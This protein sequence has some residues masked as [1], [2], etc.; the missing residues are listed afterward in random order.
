M[1]VRFVFRLLTML[2]VAVAF[3]R[4]GS[5][6]AAEPGPADFLAFVRSEGER[7]RATDRPPKTREEWEAR[8]GVIRERL[9]AAWGGFAAQ[10]APLEA[11]KLGEI[12]RD[13]YRVE[14]VTFQTLPGVR[15]LANAYVPDRPGKVP[16]VL[17]VHG[18]WPRAKQDPV[19][20]GRCIGLA[21]LG[22]FVLAVDAF[23]AGERAIGTALGEYHGA[24]TGALLFPIGRP[25]SGIQVY[26]NMRCVDYLA[27]RPEVDAAKIGVT[28]ASGG[29]N[30]SMYAGAFE[31]RF[32]AAVPVCSVGNYQAYLGAACCMCEVVP[33]A[34][35]FTE[36]G[37]L[38]G[39]T[40]PR[41]LMVI[42]ATRDAPQFSVGEAQ[43]SLARAGDIFQTLNQPGRVK[44]VIVDS[45]HDYNQ[46]MREAMYGWMTKQLKGEGDGS[47]IAEPT[48]KTEEPE[49]LRCYPGDTRPTDYVTLPKF[50]AAEARRLVA[51]KKLPESDAD[52]AAGRAALAKS[53]AIERA[54]AAPLDL[55]VETVEGQRRIAFNSEPGVRL[56]A[57]QHSAE[58]KP[59]K[60]AIVIDHAGAEAAAANPK[61]RSKVLRD[62]SWTLVT[63]DLRAT[64]KLAVKG[65]TIGEAPDHNSAEWSLWIGRPLLGQWVVDV[66]RAIDAFTAADGQAPQEVVV[67]GVGPFGVVALAAGALD[68]RIQAV[69]CDGTLATYVSEVPYRKQLIG[70]LV[71][72]L[73]RDV[74]DVKHLAALVDRPVAFDSPTR[75]D[76][77]PLTA[78]EGGAM[79]EEVKN[80]RVIVSER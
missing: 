27:S 24:M 2:V 54:V 12:Q 33:G 69:A 47:P 19:V 75:P 61:L 20:Q 77:T 43:K 78:A 59:K 58:A 51:A 42:N 15:M 32:G 73:L 65:D 50:A 55:N 23:G 6:R 62:G 37:D 79:F 38:L 3:V 28:G 48:I 44:H 49:S 60:L 7:L 46:P 70:I 17:G 72:G 71:P 53:L 16:A 35:T 31:E 63:L 76:G 68:A 80:V 5:S 26:E 66:R 67:A 64:G 39:L 29:G 11:Q 21:K 40:A 1:T 22:F 30:Q 57:R 18:H 34:L 8:K 41:G 56:I 36:E 25:L 52:V 74:G 13:G 4:G 45:A 14:R 9:A 10:A